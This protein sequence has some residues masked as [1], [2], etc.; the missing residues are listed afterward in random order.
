[1]TPNILDRDANMIHTST[2]TQT[3]TDLPHCE[4][5][6]ATAEANVYF[7]QHTLVRTPGNL[8]NRAICN[9]CSARHLPCAEPRTP[10]DKS[11]DSGTPSLLRMGWDVA[12]SL[13]AFAAD[14]ARTV[15]KEQYGV[16][17]E[18]CDGC[19]RR[20]NDRCLACGCRLS[21]KARGRAFRCPLGKWPDVNLER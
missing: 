16:R 4:L 17:L 6:V 9:Q 1:M 5:R 10:Q 11:A 8:V 19:D 18:I 14:G 13:V 2:E 15:S 3:S 21:W 7:C 12:K 20:R